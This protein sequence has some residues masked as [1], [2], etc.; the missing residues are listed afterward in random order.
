MTKTKSIAFTLI[1]VLLAIVLISSTGALAKDPA[2]LTVTPDDSNVIQVTGTGFNPSDTVK[3][4]LFQANGNVEYTW[5]QQI[6]TDVQGSFSQIVII[7]TYVSGIFSLVASTTSA[8]ANQTVEAPIL[9]GAEGPQG[10]SG[11]PGPA[12][13]S[14]NSNIAY[15]ALA[16]SL[17]TL[18]IAVYAIVKK[19]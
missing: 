7:P 2:T 18:I 11:A 9:T 17:I 1:L 14:A 8:S 15:V 4:A 16:I 13:S 3:L 12:G 19:H 5:T 10:P 6:T